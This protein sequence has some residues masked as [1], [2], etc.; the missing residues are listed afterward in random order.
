MDLDHTPPPATFP[1]T[2][3]K[4][5]KDYRKRLFDF[6]SGNKVGPG[7]AADDFISLPESGKKTDG[8]TNA[9]LQWFLKTASAMCGAK[10]P[11]LLREIE[12]IER[13]LGC[14][15]GKELETQAKFRDLA[16]A[17]YFDYAIPE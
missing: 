7:S 17:F 6:L 5:F 4:F 3:M 10:L 2:V 16:V 13:L 11:Q 14:W 8:L 9:S 12:C 15:S 1:P